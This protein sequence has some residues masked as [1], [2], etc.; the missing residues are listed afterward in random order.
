MKALLL[1]L[2][3]V[4]ASACAG[5]LVLHNQQTG[6]EIRLADGP[7]VDEATAA[8]IKDE[9]VPKFKAATAIIDGKTFAGCWLEDAGRV[10]LFFE[11]GERMLVPMSKFRDRTV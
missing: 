1:S 8:E 7:C 6:A 9:W 11:N 5:N 2:A 4:A 3:L 10:V